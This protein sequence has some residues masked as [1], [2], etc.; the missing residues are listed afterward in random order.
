LT[1]FQ[2]VQFVIDTS[3]LYFGAYEHIAATYFSNTLPHFGHCA[4]TAFSKIAG[5]VLVTIFLGLFVNFYVQTYRITI[6]SG[7]SRAN[8]RTNA[9]NSSNGTYDSEKMNGVIHRKL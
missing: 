7:S 3:V 6:T 4:G 5:A 1:T 8:S 9:E 2:I